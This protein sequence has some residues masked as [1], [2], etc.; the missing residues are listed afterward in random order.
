[1]LECPISIQ[2]VLNFKY[3]ENRKKYDKEGAQFRV[4]AV[5]IQQGRQSNLEH[6]Q[7]T[8]SK[9]VLFITKSLGKIYQS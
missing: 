2:S 1:M 8:H 6:P 4:T 3:L 9:N 5:V 7:I